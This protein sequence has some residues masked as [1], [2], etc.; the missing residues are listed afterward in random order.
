M[1]QDISFQQSEKITNGLRSILRTYPEI[2]QV[3]SQMGRPDDGTD[4]STFPNTKFLADLKPAGEWR[5]QFHKNKDELIAA[6]QNDF[7]RYPGID[8][9][10]SQNMQDNIE[11][12]M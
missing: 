8:F 1:Q 6:I 2:T 4:V 7:S 5:P 10:F 11:E 9:N 12:A 3:I